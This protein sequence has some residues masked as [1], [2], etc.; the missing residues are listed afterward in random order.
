[1]VADQIG[2]GTATYYGT[3]QAAPHVAG[4]VAL[5]LG[6]GG[7]PGLCAGLSVAQVIAKVRADAAASATTLNGFAG[8]PLRPVTGR[9]YGYLATAA[10]Y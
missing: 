9:Y 5:C 1:V 10:G 7:T 3:S 2:G 6:N 4:T 8:D